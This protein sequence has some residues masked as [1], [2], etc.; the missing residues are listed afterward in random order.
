MTG[1]YAKDTISVVKIL[2]NAVESPKDSPNKDEIKDVELSFNIINYEINGEQKIL[3]ENLNNIKLIN[4]DYLFHAG[5]RF[6]EGK[7]YSNG[8]RVLNFVSI[9]QDFENARNRAVN[10]IKK[11]NWKNGHYRKDIGYKV[12]EKK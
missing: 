4:D 10:L 7:F 6:D 1:D 8:G 11:L 9:D 2:Q 5:T 12:I 3:I